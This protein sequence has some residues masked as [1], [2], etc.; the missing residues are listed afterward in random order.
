VEVKEMTDYKMTD[1]LAKVLTELVDEYWHELAI[2]R[3]YPD[4]PDEIYF[5]CE[6]HKVEHDCNHNNRT[7]TTP[8]DA[9][10][11][12]RKLVEKRI[13]IVFECFC[14]RFYIQ[15][16]NSGNTKLAYSEW[17]HLNKERFNVL[18]GMFIKERI[19]KETPVK[20]KHYYMGCFG[21]Y[22]GSQNCDQ[23]SDWREC[24][25]K[26]QNSKDECL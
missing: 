10:L 15:E 13:F 20:S 6:T 14:I 8:D 24:K 25:E 9:D 12:M 3:P 18:A 5:V 11:V 16:F 21:D 17:L 22:D 19:N 7:F 23:C 4:H 2:V 26:E 1:A